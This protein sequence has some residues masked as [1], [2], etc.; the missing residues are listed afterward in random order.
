[1]VIKWGIKSFLKSNENEQLSLFSGL[2]LKLKWR[3]DF[4]IVKFIIT[5]RSTVY[6]TIIYLSVFVSIWQPTH[7]SLPVL[8]SQTY[9]LHLHV[10]SADCGQH[11]LHFGPHAE[12]RATENV[13]CPAPQPDLTLQP[14]RHFLTVP[15]PVRKSVPRESKVKRHVYFYFHF[16]NYL[17]E[18]PTST[19]VSRHL[20]RSC[21]DQSSAAWHHQRG[22]ILRWEGLETVRTEEITWNGLQDANRI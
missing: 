10:G 15:S 6:C 19:H 12:D 21:T 14:H 22:P 20:P 4:L 1:M 5:L 13:V 3:K 9:D 16:W 17:K 8:C 18:A 11:A 7:N 2:Q